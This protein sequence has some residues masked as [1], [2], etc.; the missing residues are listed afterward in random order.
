MPV[1]AAGVRRQRRRRLVVSD[2]PPPAGQVDVA[3][4]Q[5]ARLTVQFVGRQVGALGHAVL[6]RLAAD[7]VTVALVHVVLAQVEPM[8]TYSKTTTR[9]R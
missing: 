7:V 1:D 3:R 5:V 8:Y 6:V 4:G 2:V 9:Y